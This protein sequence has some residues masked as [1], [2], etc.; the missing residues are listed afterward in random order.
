MNFLKKNWLIKRFVIWSFLLNSFIFCIVG[1]GYLKTMLASDTL[2]QNSF[3][4][5]ESL[6]GK[7]VVISFAVLN[8]L[9]YMM[10]L[11]F[12]PGM[13]ILLIALLIPNNRLIKC[14]SFLTAVICLLA[15]IADS[16]VYSLF[17]FHINTTILGMVFDGGMLGIF[18]FSQLELGFFAI[19]IVLVALLEYW[20]VRLVWQKIVIANRFN[21]EYTILIMWLGVFLIC[22]FT[23]IQSLSKYMNIFSQQTPSL[24]WYTQLYSYLIPSSNVEDILY[25]Y[26]EHKYS[27][28]LFVTDKVKYPLTDMQC[29]KPDKP[30]NIILIMV[31]SLRFDALQEKAMPNAVRFAGKGLQ[32]KHH[33]SGGNSTQAGIFSLFY[34]L[35]SMYWSAMASYQVAPVFIDLLLANGYQFHIL[36]SQG[37]KKP[38]FYK[39]VFNHISDIAWKGGAPGYDIGDKD[40]FMTS[41]AIKFLTE[42]TAKKTKQPFFL[43]LFY[44]AAHGYCGNQSYPEEFKPAIQY[45]L[46][47]RMNNKIDPLPYHN[48]YLNAVKF[49]DGEIGKL[50]E[51]IEKQ[52]Y[53]NNSIVILT[54]DHGQEFNDN[55]QNYWEHASNFTDAQI[56][57]PLVI[58]WP[59]KKA[60]IINYQTGSYDIVPTLMQGIFGCRNP[61]ND[62]SIGQ[63]LL[64]KKERKP[65]MLVGSYVNMG[66]VE[67]ERLTTLQ[68]SGNIMITDKRAVPM[69]YAL[70]DKEILKQS[71][72]LM[73]KYYAK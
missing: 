20:L 31:D 6:L 10:L 39:T 17:R 57:V 23:L 51:A 40:R 37:I 41:Q 61:I 34:S 52:G 62:Y 13:L 58:H 3:C 32:F 2:F 9:T 25:R 47:L 54:S 68:V 14:L 42:N 55:H 73:R 64:L 16:Q 56:H 49:V 70:P 67:Q 28:P 71:M 66:I 26:S 1:A 12:L 44:D 69:E 18:G 72:Y 38:P 36:W 60:R 33:L 48:R 59:G 24:P 30:Y 27:Q 8:Y 63:N 50:L 65:F 35:P 53:L 46:R 19:I 21:I 43:S 7:A 4:R 15:I 45:C 29:R 22:Y 11:A 5:F